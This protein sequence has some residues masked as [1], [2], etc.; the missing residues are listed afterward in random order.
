[1]KPAGPP[2]AELMDGLRAEGF[3]IGV[4]DH[5]R[6]GTVLALDREWDEA[7]LRLA[8]RSVLAKDPA[9]SAAF[10]AVWKRLFSPVVTERPRV[11]VVSVPPP[12]RRR[13]PRAVLAAAVASVAVVVTLVAWLRPARHAP[14]VHNDAGVQIAQGSSVRADAAV[15]ATPDASAPV[16]QPLSAQGPGFG[17]GQVAQPEVEPA[18]EAVLAPKAQPSNER[19]RLQAAPAVVEPPS[20]RRSIIP[21]LLFALGIAISLAGLSA[22]LWLRNR[23][24][25]FVPGPFRYE[26]KFPVTRARLVHAESID[27]CAAH[28]T[29]QDSE[30]ESDEL[31][32]E[33]TAIETANRGGSPV[34]VHRTP[35]G[36]PEYLVLEDVSQGTEAWRQLYDEVLRG[37]VRE[38]VHL[39]RFTYF[40]SPRLCTSLDG[41]VTRPLREL[42][43]H[44]DALI[45]IGDAEVAYDPVTDRAADWVPTLSHVARRL[46]I[47]PVPSARWGRGADLISKNTAIA[48]GVAR[49]FMKLGTEDE[50]RAQQPHAYPAV[51]EQAPATALGLEALEGHLGPSAMRVLSALANC[52]QPTLAAARWFGELLEVDLSE[53]E[54]LRVAYTP[55]IRNGTWPAEVRTRLTGWLS[56]RDAKAAK[57]A[58]EA[59]HAHLIANE[60]PAG[61]AAH[62][63]WQIDLATAS[64]NRSRGAVADVTASPLYREV[65]TH[66]ERGRTLADRIRARVVA[67]GVAVATVAG[68]QM[69]LQRPELQPIAPR[70]DV[71]I[72]GT[73]QGMY[74]VVLDRVQTERIEADVVRLHAF[75]DAFSLGAGGAR[76]DLDKKDVSLVDARGHRLRVQKI[77]TVKRPVSL[78][79]VVKRGL[80][81]EADVWKLLEPL[82]RAL[83]S[84]SDVTIMSYCSG[85]TSPLT[86][87]ARI[88]DLN[89]DTPCDYEPDEALGDALSKATKHLEVNALTDSRKVLLVISDGMVRDSQARFRT[90][91]DRADA[92]GIRIDSIAYSPTDERRPL[93]ALADLGNRSQGVFRWQRGKDIEGITTS[94][95]DEVTQQY[96]LTVDVSASDLPT[97]LR[98]QLAGR[99][100]AKSLLAP[101]PAPS[102]ALQICKEGNEPELGRLATAARSVAITIGVVA[103]LDILCLLFALRWRRRIIVGVALATLAITGHSL[104]DL[105][106]IDEPPRA[107]PDTPTTLDLPESKATVELSIEPSKT[108][109]VPPTIV[110]TVRGAPTL[111]VT[112]VQLRAR[113][114]AYLPATSIAPSADPIAIAFL[115]STNEI[116]VGNDDYETD[117]AARYLGLL[118]DLESAIDRLNLSKIAPAGSQIMVVTYDSG[119]RVLVPPMDVATFRGE[120]LGK[121]QDYRG[122]IGNDLVSGVTL[123]SVELEKMPQRRK[124]LLVVG[125]GGDTNWETAKG[126]L[127]QL[128]KDVAQKGIRTYATIWKSAV[129]EPGT[130]IT[131]MIPWAHTV[132]SAS[133]VEAD[134]NYNLVQACNVITVTFVDK[135]G[136]LRWDGRDQTVQLKLGGEASE[137]IDLAVPRWNPPTHRSWS[138]IL[139]VSAAIGALVFGLAWFVRRRIYARR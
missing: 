66:N 35:R 120:N 31:D 93:L 136:A 139:L 101:V 124:H 77:S 79:L 48:H 11:D 94:V 42:V 63:R 91:G 27:D 13:V 7:E 133:G 122:H 110:A 123:A 107:T 8:I 23:R 85:E 39:V 52:R 38:G 116:W 65:E 137:E 34:F 68:L 106:F 47:S 10:D 76:L 16:E 70:Q 92:A 55:W 25:R 88:A 90:I 129:S 83:G 126:Q 74:R 109:D 73:Q 119:A 69:T 114:G 103:L 15:T 62:L 134:L 108:A 54:W 121:Q 71:E 1:M 84:Q 117:D 21:P 112:D 9:Q 102:C 22:T 128:K 53:D 118:K 56:E 100:E 3:P 87:S 4:D 125:D 67:I 127:M 111:N 81:T 57:Q 5:I 19:V 37:L 36:T 135:E 20:H 6:I 60:P 2:M 113:S 17:A 41:T 14:V 72:R 105:S 30:A 99:V 51:I 28:L 95:V 33:R 80:W 40:G 26:V 24:T 64:G 61:S 75:V 132:V 18:R 138:R 43:E 131:S 12:V 49:A 29:W 59:L 86:G 115:V 96:E 58:R 97:A 104:I 45:V 46:W 78:L 98:V 44:C 130:V 82:Q 89:I 50:R 32:V